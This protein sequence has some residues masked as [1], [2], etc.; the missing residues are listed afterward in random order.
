MSEQWKIRFHVRSV[1]LNV[2]KSTEKVVA[3]KVT[4]EAEVWSMK[5]EN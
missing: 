3:P 4:Y 2:K 1:R 5:E